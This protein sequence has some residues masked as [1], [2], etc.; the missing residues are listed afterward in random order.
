MYHLWMALL[1][2]KSFVLH[3]LLCHAVSPSEFQSEAYQHLAQEPSWATRSPAAQECQSATLNQLMAVWQLLTR[4][5]FVVR[6]CCFHTH[7]KIYWFTLDW[8]VLDST[9]NTL[10]PDH[11]V[12]TECWSIGASGV[13]RHANCRD[14]PL[15][16]L[17]SQLLSSNLHEKSGFLAEAEPSQVFE[18]FPTGACFLGTADFTLVENWLTLSSRLLACFWE[19]DLDDLATFAIICLPKSAKFSHLQLLMCS[20]S[21]WF[22]APN[23]CVWSSATLAPALH[24]LN[25][26]RQ[27]TLHGIWFGNPTFSLFLN[28]SDSSYDIGFWYVLMFVVFEGI[29]NAS[30]VQVISDP[31]KMHFGFVLVGCYGLLCAK[32]R[33]GVRLSMVQVSVA[34]I[35]FS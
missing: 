22:T 17:W 18:C 26:W 19:S 29:W 16:N 28:A 24:L 10:I 34:S 21:G 20:S 14:R 2:I 6:P 33:Q 25:S 32:G 11:V 5:V 7:T 8:I 13:R 4:L 30:R 31:R 1:N 27:S 12:R 3:Q 35:S 15:E 9:S 23:P